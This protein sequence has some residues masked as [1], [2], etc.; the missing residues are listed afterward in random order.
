VYADHRLPKKAILIENFKSIAIDKIRQRIESFAEII[1]APRN[2]LPTFSNPDGASPNVDID[3]HGQ[4]IYENYERG[5]QIKKVIAL[6]EF[7]LCY[8]VFEI[9]TFTMAC[10]FGSKHR[11]E[12]KDFRRIMFEKQEELMGQMMK[13]WEIRKHEDH[14][15]ILKSRPFDDFSMIRVDYYNRL[16]NSG[17]PNTDALIEVNAKYPPPDPKGEG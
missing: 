12:G 13:N 4:F 2:L 1:D 14:Q 5:K 9:V 8:Y 7:D 6:D 15:S 16:V 10:D 3:P 17:I 11:I